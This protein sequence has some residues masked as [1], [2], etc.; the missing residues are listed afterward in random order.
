MRR[1][2]QSQ[3]KA[4]GTNITRQ[5]PYVTQTSR[6]VENVKLDYSY[7]SEIPRCMIQDV[8]HAIQYPSI[9]L[10]R[11]LSH[12]ELEVVCNTLAH[13]ARFFIVRWSLS[14]VS[15]HESR[16]SC[17]MYVMRLA[18][19]LSILPIQLYPPTRLD[20]YRMILTPVA[21]TGKSKAPF[22]T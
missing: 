13:L 14:T 21:M 22:S 6:E 8:M 19:P 20:L 11:L 15:Q 7:K 1:W 4:T 5:H 3:Y 16:S 9:H 12:S 18:C 2:Y 17:L 10:R